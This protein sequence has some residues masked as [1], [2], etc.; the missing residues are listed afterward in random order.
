MGRSQRFRL[1][2]IRLTRTRCKSV[3]VKS[4]N[5]EFQE[6]IAVP[7]P[8]SLIIKINKNKKREHN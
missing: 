5:T 6:S 2:E 1:S 4:Y 8:S 3:T 7:I